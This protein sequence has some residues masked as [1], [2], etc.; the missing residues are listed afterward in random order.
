MTAIARIVLK[1]WAIPTVILCLLM[2][3]ASP[4]LAGTTITVNTTDDLGGEN[5][6]AKCSLREAII[7]ANTNLPTGGCPAGGLGTDYIYLPAAWPK[8]YVLNTP[9]EGE[10]NGLTGDLDITSSMVITGAGVDS[11]II[12]AG[13]LDR[14]FEIHS[15]GPVTI[16]NLSITNGYKI[17]DGGGIR[18]FRSNVTLTGLSIYGNKPSGGGGGVVITNGS[19]VTIRNSQITN[20]TAATGSAIVADGALT[21]ENSFIH[22]NIS[23]GSSSTGAVTVSTY[24]GEMVS[25]INTTIA[26]NSVPLPKLAAGVT[27]SSSANL[28]MQNVTIVNNNGIGL[29]V[30]PDGQV[31]TRN[32]IIARQKDNKD[33]CA[34]I[35]GALFTTQGNNLA[36]DTTCLLDK[37]KGDKVVADGALFIEDQAYFNG[38]KTPTFALLEGSPAIDGG[39]NS[40]CPGNDQRGFGRP[41]DGDNNGSK[42][43]DIGAFELGGTSFVVFVPTV[44]R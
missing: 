32:T 41:A 10:H 9:G 43:C 4:V 33:D 29:S 14:A 26:E 34:I 25:I 27:V 15:T 30:L 2:T 16:S 38:G 19:N 12:D 6:T 22:K 17:Q 36:S 39:S 42:V 24:Y 8:K 28:R 3:T 37:A 21:L 20:N 35:A 7:S 13:S 31:A 44:R 5:T 23:I 11:V 40:G 1:G 18:I